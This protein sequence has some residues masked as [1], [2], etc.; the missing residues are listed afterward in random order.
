MINCKIFCATH[1]HRPLLLIIAASLSFEVVLNKSLHGAIKLCCLLP[2]P[3]P[4]HGR[5]CNFV[6]PVSLV[7]TSAPVAGLNYLTKWNE[8]ITNY[9]L[10]ISSSVWSVCV[11]KFVIA[12]SYD[13]KMEREG[14]WDSAASAVDNSPQRGKDPSADFMEANKIC[15]NFYKGEI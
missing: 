8:L 9:F 12:D 13:I 15:W 14:R 4:A 3:L 1:L 7:L 5:A 11:W 2:S 10:F 6:R